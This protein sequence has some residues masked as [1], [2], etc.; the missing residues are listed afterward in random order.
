MQWKTTKPPHCRDN[1]SRTC[2]S[3]LRCRQVLLERLPVALLHQ[4]A[5]L[6]VDELHLPADPDVSGHGVEL[7][8]MPLGDLLPAEGTGYILAIEQTVTA[9]FA[10]RHRCRRGNRHQGGLR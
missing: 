2:S 4:P 6:F 9:P 1:R 7:E 8:Q 5:A 3:G 10:D